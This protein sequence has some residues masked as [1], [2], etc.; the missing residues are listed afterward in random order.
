MH[1]Q[2][3]T[4]GNM[5]SQGG[6]NSTDGPQ[7]NGCEQLNSVLVRSLMMFHFLKLKILKVYFF[8]K[9]CKLKCWRIPPVNLSRIALRS[10]L[11]VSNVSSLTA[12]NISPPRLSRH[13]RNGG[14]AVESVFFG[15]RFIASKS[16]ATLSRF[17]SVFLLFFFWGAFFCC[18][19]FFLYFFTRRAF[20]ASESLLDLSEVMGYKFLFNLLKT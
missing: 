4:S 17:K 2:R 18:C 3:Q 8:L 12:W 7:T 13:C 15:D 5:H 9:I 10:D 14:A 16:I 20:F 6:S 19:Y 1:Y 11:N